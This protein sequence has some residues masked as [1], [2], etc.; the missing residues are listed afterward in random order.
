MWVGAKASRPN[1]EVGV[2]ASNPKL[3]VDASR[4]NFELGVDAPRLLI[5][6]KIKIIIT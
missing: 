4:P 3:G 6:I 2:D 5:I 1:L